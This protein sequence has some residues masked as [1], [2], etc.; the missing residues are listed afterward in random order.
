VAFENDFNQ[1]ILS[2]NCKPWGRPVVALIFHDEEFPEK[3]FSDIDVGNF[4]S[5]ISTGASTHGVHSRVSSTGCVRY[6]W[7]AWHSGAGDPYNGQTEGYEHDGYAHQTRAEWLDPYGVELLERSARHMAKRCHELG[8]PVRKIDAAQLNH[9]LR[10]QNP[11]DGGIC[12]HHDITIAA[13]VRGGHTDP[14]AN[15]PWDY[16]I[17]RVRAHYDGTAGPIPDPQVPDP[18]VNRPNSGAWEGFATQTRLVQ[19]YLNELGFNAGADDGIFGPQTEAAVIAFQ[20]KAFDTTGAPLKVDGIVGPLTWTSICV[21]VFVLRASGQPDFVQHSDPIPVQPYMVS[22]GIYNDPVVSSVQRR[23]RD[24]G[25][26]IAVDGSF[27][28]DTDTIVRAFQTEKGLKVDGVVGPNT[29]NE[30]FRT[31]NIT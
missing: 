18:V 7:A 1:I 19:Q 11:A 12:S 5:K 16:Y 25:W 27:G 6:G 28:P 20:S 14:G 4:F 17:D 29:W 9:A 2:P 8:I 26:S 30:L 22:V 15:F 3:D 24:R 31:D 13:S 10:T 21:C 23:L